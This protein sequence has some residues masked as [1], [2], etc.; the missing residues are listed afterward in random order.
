MGCR[1]KNENSV[2]WQTDCFT[3][4]GITNALLK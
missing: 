1:D 2:C 3:P 4:T